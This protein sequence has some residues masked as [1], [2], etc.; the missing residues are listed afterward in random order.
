LFG[1]CLKD[2]SW[3]SSIHWNTS[4]TMY[5]RLATVAYDSQ[6]ISILSVETITPPAAVP[7][8]AAAFAIW[9]NIVLA[10]VPSVL[11]LTGNETE[12]ENGATSYNVEY[13]LS[14]LLR[15]YQSDYSSYQDGGLSL[16]RSF[17]AVPFQFSTALQ[18]Q[19]RGS[20]SLPPA[21]H[22]SANLSKSSYRA[23][24]DPWTVL[25]FALLAASLT[26][27]GVA[28]LVWLS[29]YA[30]HSPN[31]SFFPEVDITSKSGAHIVRARDAAATAAALPALAVADDTLEDLGKLTRMHGLGNGMSREVVRAIRGKRVY[32][33]SCPGPEDGE[34][35]IVLVTER[36]Q[37]KLL[38]LHEK[39]A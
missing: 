5:S 33:G 17:L 34:N 32:C 7:V 2:L 9:C 25:V 31:T 14:F 23:I 10:P 24:V 19:T 39:Y 18:Q 1:Q 26:T 22:V 8:P 29:F 38:N 16:L 21:N 20:Y 28:W 13:S 37:V 36:G 27:W 35:V 4:V 3:A 30:P 11:N 6:N 12:F 15:L